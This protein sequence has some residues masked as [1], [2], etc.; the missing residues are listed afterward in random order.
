MEAHE[1][2]CTA[3]D[4]ALAQLRDGG[5]LDDD[6]RRLVGASVNGRHVPLSQVLRH[7]DVVG[8]ITRPYGVRRPRGSASVPESLVQVRGPSGHGQTG[9][10]ISHRAPSSSGTDSSHSLLFVQTKK[11]V[12]LWPWCLVGDDDAITA[13]RTTLQ[14]RPKP[15]RLL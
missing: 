7:G 1:G 2:V 4:A 9:R 6:V 15:F 3:R 10:C 5:G 11:P 13:D 12:R 8:A 14:V